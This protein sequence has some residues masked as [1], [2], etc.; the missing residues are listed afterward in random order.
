LSIGG[1]EELKQAVL[2]IAAVAKPGAPATEAEAFERALCDAG[3]SLIAAAVRLSRRPPSQISTEPSANTTPESKCLPT[4]SNTATVN[5]P[6]TEALDVDPQ[7]AEEKN[8][9]SESGQVPAVFQAY[10][11]ERKPHSSG[12][13]PQ[14]HKVDD[15]AVDLVGLAKE[16]VQRHAPSFLVGDALPPPA[17][18]S[19]SATVCSAA[20]G[21]QRFCAKCKHTYVSGSYSLCYRCRKRLCH[22]ENCSSR[23]GTEYTY[24]YPCR[25]AWKI[26]SSGAL[27]LEPDCWGLPSR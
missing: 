22:G 13:S 25:K 10:V 5:T 6:S 24:C 1:D 14:D 16:S 9:S 8:S 20:N 21:S 11:A 23:V 17:P 7:K 12:A 2:G 15:A 27:V 19:A 4:L 26:R 18:V 3:L